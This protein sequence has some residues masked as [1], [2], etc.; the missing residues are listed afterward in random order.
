METFN[1]DSQDDSYLRFN[2]YY[3]TPRSLTGV[4]LPLVLNTAVSSFQF[5]SCL[6]MRDTWPSGSDV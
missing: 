1:F 2:V 4:K 5:S 6:V 3:D